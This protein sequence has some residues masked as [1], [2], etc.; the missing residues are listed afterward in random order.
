MQCFEHFSQKEYKVVAE[1]DM[2]FFQ[3]PLAGSETILKNL[4]LAT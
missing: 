3:N 4:N 2:H 1:E